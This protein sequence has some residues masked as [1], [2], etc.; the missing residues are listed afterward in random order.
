MCDISQYNFANSGMKTCAKHTPTDCSSLSQQFDESPV[1]NVVCKRRHNT[2]VHSLGH[3]QPASV[4]H[5]HNL[6]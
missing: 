4:L 6:L 2:V 5:K 3:E 1:K